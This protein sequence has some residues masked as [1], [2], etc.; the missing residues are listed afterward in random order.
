MRKRRPLKDLDEA[1]SLMRGLFGN[2]MYEAK[3]L[4]DYM[5]KLSVCACCSHVFDTRDPRHRVVDGH[6]FCPACEMESTTRSQS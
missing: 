1:S 4:D 6:H 5:Q 2:L 3:S